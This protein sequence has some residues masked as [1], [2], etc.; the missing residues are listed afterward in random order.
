MSKDRISNEVEHGKY[1][2]GM[3][4][5]RLWYWSS[6]AGQVRLKRRKEIM[7]RYVTSNMTVLELGC[8][9]G[10]FTLALAETNAKIISID[11]SPDLV[12]VAK[13]RIPNKNVSIQVE[14][15][16]QLN[17]KDE[18][19]DAVLGNSILHHLKMRTAL[20][21]VLRVLK[22]GGK[23]FFFEPNLLNPLQIIELSTPT[24]RKIT[25]HSPDET[26]IIRWKLIKL[27]KEVGFINVSVSPFDFLH[28]S[29]P[30]LLIPIVEKIG[31]IAEKTPVL[32]E[33]SGSLI[34]RG[35]KPSNEF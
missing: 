6:P 10:D 5:G 3:D 31:S 34:V 13:K 20:K 33:I 19:F 26:A 2:A 18:T 12:E 17:H 30:K 1:L 11:I 28:P 32:K 22:P 35:D 15:A 24:M 14:N 7:T 25:H 29:T 9:P 4:A 8:G 16:Y 27:L 21:D 23:I